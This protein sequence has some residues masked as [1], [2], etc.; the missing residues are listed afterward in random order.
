MV[1]ALAEKLKREYPA[2]TVAYRNGY[3]GDKDQIFEEIAELQPDL[4][5]VVLWAPPPRSC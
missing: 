1:S 5:L 4:V 2:V 3:D